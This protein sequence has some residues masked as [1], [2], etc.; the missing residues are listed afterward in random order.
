MAVKES[1]AVGPE[2]PV[3]R[4]ITMGQLLQEAAE[5]CP[6]QLALIAGVDDPTERRQ[7]TYAQLYE[8]SLVVARALR[9][10]FEPGTHITIWA[11]N[12]PEWVLIEFGAALG[13]MVLVTANPSFQPAEIAYVLKQSR[14]AAVFLF[15]E[16]RGNPMLKHLESVK[17]DCPELREVILIDEWDAF[18]ATGQ[19]SGIELPEI[20]PGDACMIQYT[21]GT[22]GFPKGALLHHRGLVN[23][24]AH[25]INR[26]GVAEGSAWI[27]TMPLFH[28]GGCVACVLGATSIRATQ[29]LIEQFD[30]RL[31][32]ELAETYQA[33]AMLG[34]P[35]MLV[36]MIE[37]PDFPSRDLSS[38]HS[39]CSGGATP[40]PSRRRCARRRSPAHPAGRSD[41]TVE[42]W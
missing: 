42:G 28:T 24:G 20:Q 10:R 33:A 25:I 18:M 11:P 27:T 34:V 12:V 14:S 3:L 22:T 35:T 8:E 31:V 15:S 13:G 4:D 38:V 1:W 32:L 19:N 37:H 26:M 5:E 6:E 2:V 9:R 17:A 39:V 7:W 41:A 21:S 16:F 40:A 36:A 23:N 29:L 30:P